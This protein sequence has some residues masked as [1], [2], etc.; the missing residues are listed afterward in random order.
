MSLAPRAVFGM[1]TL[2]RAPF[3][4]E[5]LESLLSQTYRDFALI[6]VDDGST[7]DTCDITREYAET[8]E[9][10]TLYRNETRLGT[11]RNWC[12]AFDLARELHPRSEYF[13]WASDHDVWHP[14]WLEVL[15]AELDRYPDVV[16]AYPQ[17]PRI[18]EMGETVLDPWSFD[19][20]GLTSRR[21][22]LRRACR[23]ISAGSMVYGLYR[24]ETVAQAGVFRPVLL[25]DRLLLAELSLYGQFKQ[26]DTVLWYRRFARRATLGRQ[27]SN[28]FPEGVPIH[29]YLPW[30]AVHTAVLARQLSFRGAA[31]PTISRPWGLIHAGAYLAY[32]IEHDARRR[33]RRFRRWLLRPVKGLVKET[34]RYLY[35]HLR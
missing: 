7:D 9:R 13:A 31:A 34:L 24:A 3:L 4:R 16:L 27:R 6:V 1:L 22:R 8:D 21:E 12:R 29:S 10:I 33:V 5:T 32:S 23:G 18:T 30:W 26:V 20:F 11:T 17:S 15:T 2:N 25:P 14:R 28:F 19:T 35:L